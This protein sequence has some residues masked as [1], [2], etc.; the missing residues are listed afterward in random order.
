MPQISRGTSLETMVRPRVQRATRMITAWYSG[1]MSPAEISVFCRL[2]RVSS[3][4]ASERAMAWSATAN[5]SMSRASPTV[6]VTSRL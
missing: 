3:T 6:W 4:T 1:L 5:T 2:L